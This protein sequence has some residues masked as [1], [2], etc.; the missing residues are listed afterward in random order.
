[1]SIQNIISE[2]FRGTGL[3]S[4]NSTQDE[5]VMLEEA[6]EMTDAYA[7]VISVEGAIDVVEGSIAGL[8]SLQEVLGEYR[9]NG[10]MDEQSAALLNASVSAVLSHLGGGSVGVVPSQE[11]F[12]DEGGR[13]EAT[14]IAME[15]I[16]ETIANMWEAIMRMIT[17]AMEAIKN[18][19][20]STERAFK[21]IE[22]TAKALIE[23]YENANGTPEKDKI[24]VKGGSLLGKKIEANQISSRIKKIDDSRSVLG[25]VA[26]EVTSMLGQGNVASED[27]YKQA[28]KT[29][30]DAF[31][32][33]AME[34]V[35]VTIKYEGS[36]DDKVG[37]LNFEIK[38]EEA[39]VAALAAADL[40][41][42][43]E[44]V[45]T[46]VGV[47]KKFSKEMNTAITSST[48]VL[49]K[50]GSTAVKEARLDK[51]TENKEVVYIKKALSLSNKSLGMVRKFVVG[52]TKYGIQFLTAALNLAKASYSNLKK[53]K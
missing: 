14:T 46:Q 47:L 5:L 50:T 32:P 36:S 48:D 25:G 30:N 23:K 29:V 20:S 3:E 12:S 41:P 15:G 17:K 53:D 16:G 31:S 2:T 37:T 8:E 39:E 43:A 21:S 6:T 27:G 35:G 10:G 33:L 28:I 38:S 1:M 13:L 51:D 49:K 7:E 40:K 9:K 42:V 4:V 45:K 24:K 34:G 52:E 18:F 44:E 22:K 19:F 11:S 26:V